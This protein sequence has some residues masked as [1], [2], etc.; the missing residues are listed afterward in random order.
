MVK[1]AYFYR[2]LTNNKVQ[3]RTCAHFCNLVPEE[4]GEC[5]V[6]KNIDGHLYS[7]VYGQAAALNVDPIEKKPLFH[8]YPGTSSLSVGT[9]GCPLA[10]ANCQNWS[11]SQGPKIN[12]TIEGRHVS[13]E[14]IVTTAKSYNS[15]T[16]SYTYTEPTA[17]LEYALDTMKLARAEGLKNCLVSHGFMSKES[18][19]AIIPYLDAN[20]IDIKSFSNEFYKQNCN[21]RLRPVLDTAKMMKDA[22]VWIEIT[23]LAIP[24]LS[25][26][27]EMFNDIAD[28]IYRELG[29]ETPWH[30]TRFS[31]YISWKLHHLPDTP[32]RTL[33]KGYKI[34][35]KR[36]LNHVYLGNVPGNNLENTYCPGCEALCIDRTGFSLNRYDKHGKCPHCDA[37]LHIID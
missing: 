25:D 21:A 33:Q 28:F 14:E 4:T 29:P 5:G 32:L 1:E 15:P 13:P 8:F 30:I 26:S 18:A 23:T 35:K 19:S 20:N 31:G 27:E 17:F 10:C 24:T 36:G 6:R 34:G 22:G 9:S 37:D 3:C 12:S 2:K 7:L 11:L 16:I